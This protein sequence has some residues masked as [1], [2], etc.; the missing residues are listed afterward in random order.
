MR[1]SINRVWNVCEEINLCLIFSLPRTEF[2]AYVHNLPTENFH[3]RD[4]YACD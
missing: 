1:K 2:Q 4:K 3:I